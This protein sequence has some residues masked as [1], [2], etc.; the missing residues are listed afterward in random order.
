MRDLGLRTRALLPAALAAVGL[1]AAGAAAAAPAA[2]QSTGADGGVLVRAGAAGAR[3]QTPA[4]R[5]LP[6]ALPAGA[7]LS[8]VAGPASG[9]AAAGTTAERGGRTGLVVVAGDDAT[10]RRLPAPAPAGARLRT[11]PVPL[12]GDCG[13]VGLAWLEG[14]DRGSLG[15]RAATWDGAAWSPVE[16]VAAPGRGSQLALAGAVLADGSW[17][18]AW[19][20]FDGSDDEIL[21]SLR[22]DGAWSKPRRVAGDDTVPDITPALVATDRGALLAWSRYDGSDYRLVASSFDGRGWSAVETV[23]PAGSMYPSF[24]AAPVAG[25]SVGAYLLYRT[26]LPRG[27]QVV[28]VERTGTR[29]RVA[30]VTAAGS[31]RPLVLPAEGHGVRLL[32]D[33]GAAEATAAW[34]AGR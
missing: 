19:A 33:G 32:F 31:E 9:W 21:W 23:G 18:L 12:V 1:L 15:V 13:L 24:V 6:L 7:A 3:L 26:A 8:A 2:L 34:R 27:W 16:V 11:Q 29:G 17:L 5:E 28:E 10:A 30:A 4:G 14:N 20:A 22:R 25:G